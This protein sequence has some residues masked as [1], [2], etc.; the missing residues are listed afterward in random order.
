MLSLVRFCFV[1][2]AMARMNTCL[3]RGNN[4]RESNP[5]TLEIPWPVI[6]TLEN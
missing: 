4:I 5:E 3:G 1:D 6:E 2:L